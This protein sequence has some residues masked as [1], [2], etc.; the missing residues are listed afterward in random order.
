MKKH[1]VRITL[2]VIALILLSASLPLSAA[3][4]EDPDAPFAYKTIGGH[5]RGYNKKAQYIEFEYGDELLLQDT[6]TFSPDVAK[7][8]VCLAGAAYKEGYITPMLKQMGFEENHYT[9]YTSTFDNNDVVSFAIG[10]K[11]LEEIGKKLVIVAIKGTSGDYEWFSNFNLGRGFP[12]DHKGFRDAAELVNAELEGF[13]ADCIFLVTGHSRGAAVANLVASD[14]SNRVGK[15]KVFGY[16]FACPNTTQAP[17]T[18]LTNIYNINNDGGDI[19]GIVPMGEGQWEHAYGRH[20]VSNYHWN[21][22]SDVLAMGG[23]YSGTSDTVALAEVL[24]MVVSDRDEFYNPKQHFIVMF[25]AHSLMDPEYRDWGKFLLN[26]G[27]PLA[28]TLLWDKIMSST[29]LSMIIGAVETGENIATLALDLRNNTEGM[30]EEEFAQYLWDHQEEIKEITSYT[31]EVIESL[32][33]VEPV[34][35]LVFNFAPLAWDLGKVIACIADYVDH[36]TGKLNESFSCPHEMETYALGV[37]H[38][39][40]GYRAYANSTNI[41]TAP[42][43]YPNTRTIGSECF[44]GCDNLPA[45]NFE[46]I[47]CIGNYAFSGCANLSS[48]ATMDQIVHIG[49]GAFDGCISLPEVTINRGIEE[50]S[51]YAFYN[52]TGL[53]EVT[54]PVEARELTGAF[55]GCENVESIHYTKGSTGI[56]AERDKTFSNAYQDY[57]SYSARNTLKHVDFEEGVISIAGEAFRDCIALET[58]E[59]P[60]T[61]ERIGDYAFANAGAIKMTLPEGLSTLGVGS[62]SCS[63]ITSVT[64]PSS[65][66]EI[67]D[68]CFASCSDLVSVSLPETLLRIGGDAF[69]S[70]T[71]LPEVTINRGVEEIDA[72]AFYNCTGL[73]EVTLP[74]EARELTGAFWGCENVE[75]IHYTKGSTGIM[76][77]RDK[78]FSNAYQDYLS[79]SARNTLKH[80]DFEE[81][82]ISI[83]GEAFRDCIAL[84]TVEFPGTLERIGDYAFAN[85]GA[86]KM[87]LPEGLSTLGVGSFS[88]SRI[89]S[90]TIPNSLAEIPGECFAGCYGL[91][92]VYA[93]H[94]D[95]LQTID[96]TA[97]S[98][99][100][101]T[102]AFYGYP[103]TALASFAQKN[104]F[105]F[106]SL[107][108]KLIPDFVLPAFLK[109]I[110]EEAFRGCA[111]TA[112][113]L[114]GQAAAIGP[115]AFTDCAELKQINIPA[116]VVDIADDAFLGSEKVII[117]CAPGSEA[118]RYAAAHGLCYVAE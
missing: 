110:G 81:G 115:L 30:T 47:R 25:L 90:V 69:Q 63:R 78:T 53:K 6:C 86:I 102:T 109:E 40:L 76:A 89:T 14:L 17:N 67:S 3:V 9:S 74:V 32:A 105:V 27:A 56:M 68:C 39:Y 79:Y 1:A 31:G 103:G 28:G 8:A 94:A 2:I 49:D 100:A 34:T 52:C 107:L 48:A 106:V 71:S 37:T 88:C 96:E 23:S 64:I 57:L 83:A 92:A 87:T 35:A 65:I 10:T 82:V 18:S 58:V 84:E 54:L 4:A 22:A 42:Y 118:E 73:K 80:V 75:S 108:E 12:T 117:Y 46:G 61:L 85:A 45:F 101:E 41:T 104:G 21:F 33:D 24:K 44:S 95:A 77:E 15:S 29:G 11:P 113:A 38:R 93:H 99:C 72:Y 112:V 98:G 43:I 50:I 114:P 60:G 62:F 70:C 59:F 111:F 97:F 91:K 66:T 5:I 7:M 36:S 51:T 26:Y 55:W 16:T 13:G 116:S 20:G 19:V